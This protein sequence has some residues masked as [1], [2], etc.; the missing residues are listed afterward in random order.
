MILK[1]QSGYKP[2]AKI[3]RDGAFSVSRRDGMRCVSEKT[4]SRVAKTAI[5][6]LCLLFAGIFEAG[7]WT[8]PS[9]GTYDSGSGTAANP[10]IIKNVAQFRYFVE[11]VAAGSSQG[12]YYRLDADID[13]ASENGTCERAGHATAKFMGNF[14]GANHTLKN[15]SNENIAGISSNHNQGIFGYIEYGSVRNL[16]TADAHVTG[17]DNVGI[18]AG[19]MF[20]GTLE[21]CYA[22]G[23]VR[24]CGHNAGG[25]VGQVIYTNTI[26]RCSANFIVYNGYGPIGVWAAQVGGLIGRVAY[27]QLQHVT[28]ITDCFVVVAFNG[29]NWKYQ[30][31]NS[32]VDLGGMIGYAGAPVKMRRVV[33]EVYGFTSF[34]YNY[35]GSLVGDCLY[36]YL[37][38]QD[39]FSNN[40]TFLGL[41]DYRNT[42]WLRGNAYHLNQQITAEWIWNRLERKDNNG[43]VKPSS[44]AGSQI[45]GWRG[46]GS[47]Y[48]DFCGWQNPNYIIRIRAGANATLT[49]GNETNVST[50]YKGRNNQF[51]VT[52]SVPSENV[53]QRNRY[54]SEMKR[55]QRA[56]PI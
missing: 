42:G 13:F 37:D 35:R 18:L 41:S 8:T 1:I 19:Y 7:A 16:N 55:S 50:L 23:W 2:T 25:L 21:N 26:N 32:I 4:L 20:T 38:C 10:Y 39:V 14:D 27:T 54:V 29:G 43:N 36:G 34:G 12:V 3:G 22:H 17:G 52:S 30:Q 51:T 45:W 5:I 46:S 56:K 24:T 11:R 44:L 49:M 53:H 28:S 9:S 15:W 47:Y 6:C 48:P 31:N 40:S 33:G